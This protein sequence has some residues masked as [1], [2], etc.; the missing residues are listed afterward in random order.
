LKNLVIHIVEDDIIIAM[1]M[2]DMLEI[3]GHRVESISISYEAFMRKL[4]DDHSDLYLV[5]I[6]LRGEKNGIDVAKEL[7]IRSIPHIYVSSETNKAILKQAEETKPNCYLQKPF[8]MQDLMVA[9]Q[10]A[11]AVKDFKR[12]ES[13]SGVC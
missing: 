11:S 2:Q 10:S 8:D 12:R 7:A 13:H 6:N 5:D 9:I 4:P 3:M 1:D